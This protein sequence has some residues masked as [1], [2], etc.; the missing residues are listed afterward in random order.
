MTNARSAVRQAIAHLMMR[1]GFSPE[2]TAC[3]SSNRG[4]TEATRYGNV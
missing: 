1:D 4:K 2:V 3:S